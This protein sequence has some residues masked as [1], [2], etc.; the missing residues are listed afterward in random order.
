MGSIFTKIVTFCCCVCHKPLTLRFDLKYIKEHV[1][2][3]VFILNGF[4]KKIVNAIF[5][6]NYYVFS[7]EMKI[8]YSFYPK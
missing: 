8:K 7:P 6:N 1:G 5:C 2:M 4:A 3:N